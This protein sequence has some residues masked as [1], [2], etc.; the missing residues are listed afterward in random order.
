MIK[1][2]DKITGNQYRLLA[3]ATRI[4]GDKCEN[5]IVYHPDDNHHSVLVMNY[6]EFGDK[7]EEIFIEIV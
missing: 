3:H 2:K 1:Y 7:Y 6:A 4:Y 5:V